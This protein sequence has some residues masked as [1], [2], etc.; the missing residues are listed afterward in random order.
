MT[1]ENPDKKEEREILR[2]IGAAPGD[3]ALRLEYAR[4]LKAH[5]DVPRGEFIELECA[6]AAARSEQSNFPD[7]ESWRAAH[8]DQ[9]R[10]V[11][12][13]S[14]LRKQHREAWEAPLAE[15][16]VSHVWFRDRGFPQSFRIGSTDLI[17]H[18]EELHLLAP[19]LSGLQLI[20]SSPEDIAILAQ[21]PAVAAILDNLDFL[22]INS[23]YLVHVD[24]SPLIT[25]P[26]LAG[27]RELDCWMSMASDGSIKDGRIAAEAIASSEYLR[28]LNELSLHAPI[29]A[30][31]V[32]ALAASSNLDGVERLTL[33]CWYMDDAAA[34]ILAQSTHLGS[35]ANLGIGST[36]I[37]NQGLLAIAK[38]LPSLRSMSTPGDADHETQKAA[39]AIIHER[40]RTW[41]ARRNA[42]AHT[43]DTARPGRG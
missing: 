2:K 29:D 7:M 4:W 6:I 22:Q 17:S 20:I 9:K 39:S 36:H 19:L 12:K 26:H 5:G 40:H 14:E 16:G 24:L 23:R 31:G 18:A 8:P 25:S 41:L 27:L 13:A 3:D 1:T 15:L 34:M 21:S 30:D 42:E 11:D 33:D 35:L 38:G 43:H 28:Q 10:M 37:Y 32:R